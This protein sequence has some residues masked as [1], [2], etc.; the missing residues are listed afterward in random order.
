VTTASPT[1]ARPARIAR[2][3][4]LRDAFGPLGVRNYRLYV[5]SQVLMNTS[6]WAARVAQNWL[7]LSLTGSTALVGLTVAFQF[8]P[9]VAFGLHGGVVA[10]RYSRRTILVVTQLSFALSMLGIGLLAVTGHVRPWHVLLAA[11]LTGVTIAYDNPSRQAFVYEIAGP[12]HM[13]RAISI[14][15]AV[16]QLGALVGPAV[17]GVLISAVGEGWAFLLNAAACFIAMGLVVAMRVS[18]LEP[19]QTVVRAKGQLREG[20]AYSRRQPA[21]LWPTVLIGAAALTGINMTTVLAAYTDDVFRDGAGGYALL[22]SMLAVGGVVGSLVSTRSTRTRLRHLAGYAAVIGALLLALAATSSHALFLVLLVALGTVALVYLTGSNSLVQQV[23]PDE[24]RG[25][26]MALYLLVLVG[27]QAA[28]GVIVGW[29]SE[30]GGAPLAMVVSAAGPLLGALAV[31]WAIARGE[32]MHPRDVVPQL[33]RRAVWRPVAPDPAPAG[34]D[35]LPAVAANDAVPAP[36]RP[37][38]VSSLS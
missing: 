31:A 21:V 17:A 5:A 8:A 12:E 32:G 34:A 2:A 28:S 20:L 3:T 14:N 26:V 36:R 11:A 6:G 18:E 16:F 19:T 37:G 10:D 4:S 38:A 22:T 9:S 15:S 33:P 24:L 29:V 25:R 30:H 1:L 23:V 13:R 27:A 35:V 7:V